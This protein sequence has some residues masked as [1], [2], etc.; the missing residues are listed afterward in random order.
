VLYVSVL[1]KVLEFGVFLESAKPFSD[2]LNEGDMLNQGVSHCVGLRVYDPGSIPSS[3][4]Y[5]L[6]R[7]GLSAHNA[8][9]Q[10]YRPQF[11]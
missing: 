6:V 11:P 3:L 2:S 8:S 7:T 1:R 5:R 9:R 10:R 4:T